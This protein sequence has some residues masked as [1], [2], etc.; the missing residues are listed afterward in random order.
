[1]TTT[2]A[3]LEPRS[4]DGGP[5]AGAVSQGIEPEYKKTWEQVA[6]FLFITVPFLAVIAAIPVAWGW[7][8]SWRDIII[9]AVMYAITGH[10]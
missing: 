8:L 3:L 6:L 7:G 10:G 4:P 9:A 1:M 2:E 5:T